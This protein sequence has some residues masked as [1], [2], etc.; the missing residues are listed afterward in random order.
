MPIFE[1][2]LNTED[3][4]CHDCNVGYYDEDGVRYLD[5]DYHNETTGEI[6]PVTYELSD[7]IAWEMACEQKHNRRIA[8][9]KSTVKNR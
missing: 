4:D 9:A 3:G 2:T 1:F 6:L 7:Y 5:D 8:Y